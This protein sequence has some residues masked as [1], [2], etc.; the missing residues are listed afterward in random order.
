MIKELVIPS[1]IYEEI[2]K[3]CSA[4][5]PR[6]ACGVA[7]SNE[8]VRDGRSCEI[9]KIYP[10]KNVSDTPRLCYLIDPEEQLQVFKKI[11]QEGLELCG[12]YHSH[13]NTEAF[14]SAKDLELAFYPSAAYVIVS[15][16][17]GR[18]E[19]VLRAF[20]ILNNKDISEI[21]VVRK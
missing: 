5:Y 3:H 2:L 21:K 17:N 15:F 12:I 8:E 20:N 4:E 6:E 14:P 10:M 11:R 19:P 7:A 13:A 9:K 1:E 18:Q 16:V